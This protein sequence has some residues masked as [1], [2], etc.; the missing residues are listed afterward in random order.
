MNYDNHLFSINS[1]Y[2]YYPLIKYLETFTPRE[3][4]MFAAKLRLNLKPDEITRRVNDLIV[5]LGLTN[6]CD[7][8]IGG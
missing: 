8:M 1:I 3:A 5:Q 6:C 4:F 7:T 2:Y